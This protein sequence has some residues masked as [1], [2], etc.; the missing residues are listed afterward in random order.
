[1]VPIKSAST[2]RSVAA[3][4][5]RQR[6]K[7]PGPHFHDYLIFHGKLRANILD[8]LYMRFHAG[9]SNVRLWNNDA[10]RHEKQTKKNGN[11]REIIIKII[12]RKK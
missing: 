8:R 7:N 12:I 3:K 9:R 1:M 6:Q 4:L 11:E 5:R 2:R 10:D